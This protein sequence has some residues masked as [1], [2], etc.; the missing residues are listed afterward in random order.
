MLMPNLE[1][2]D[3]K[4]FDAIKHEEKRQNEGIELIPSENYVSVAVLEAMGSLMTNK[5]SEGYPGKRYYGGQEFVDMV[6]NLAI[7]R[8]KQLFGAE[9]VNVQPYSGS[10]ANSAVYFALLNYG[11]TVLGMKLDHGGHITHGL[12]IS[13][14]GKSYNFIG[15]GVKKETGYID[16][17]EVRKLAHEHKPKMIVAGFSAYSRNADWKIF[18]E[19]AD[20]VGALTMADI[21][22]IAGLIAAGVIDSPVPYFDIVTTTTHKT[23]RGPRGAMIMCKEKFAKAIDRAVFPGLQG[24]PH[25]HIIAGKA[26]AFKEAMEPTFK[27]YAAQIIKNAKTLAKELIKRNFRIIS[28]GTDNHLMLIDLTNKGITGKQAQDALDMAGITCNKNTIPFE[29]RSPMDPSGI[30]IGTPAITT[31]GMKELEM[32]KIAEWID[33]AISNWQEKEKLALI[34]EEVK[35]LCLKFPVPGASNEV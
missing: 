29:T 15:Y 20:E 2:C 31:R 23:L 7:E 1:S 16:M 14:S 18:K 34:K 8:A 30:R 10:P 3:K 4:I 35:A 24:G 27:E 28:D 25:E 26:V 12:P 13:F 22:H 17:D 32:I 5:Y 6:E 21:A 9:H 33:Q 11:D 19:I